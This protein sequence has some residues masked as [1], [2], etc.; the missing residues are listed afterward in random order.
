MHVG[1]G[2][3]MFPAENSP[4]EVLQAQYVVPLDAQHTLGELSR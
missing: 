4:L 1:H 2:T 3:V